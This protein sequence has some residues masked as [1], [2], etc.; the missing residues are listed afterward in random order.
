[1]GRI[2][3]SSKSCCS[4][5]PLLL[6]KFLIAYFLYLKK[7]KSTA[8]RLAYENP[9]AQTRAQPKL[10]RSDTHI[11]F[12]SPT[13]P[14]PSSAFFF[15]IFLFFS[16]FP[17]QKPLPSRCH[18]GACVARTSF[19]PCNHNI[20]HVEYWLKCIS[21]F[22]PCRLH[23][24]VRRLVEQQLPPGACLLSQ[25]AGLHASSVNARDLLGHLSAPRC[26]QKPAYY[27]TRLAS[28][29][30]GNSSFP[31]RAKGQS[32][33]WLKMNVW[34]ACMHLRVVISR[35]TCVAWEAILPSAC[36]ELFCI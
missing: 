17:P 15:H 30:R 19:R 2:R 20:V 11:S 12:T 36:V 27:R 21:R 10:C 6:R 29:T 8:L 18:P 33:E 9:G 1:M 22:E 24:S 3:H 4:T 25:W 32:T 14:Q 34:C 5:A 26:R 23:H 35:M 28:E 16:P 31:R 7:K 13:C